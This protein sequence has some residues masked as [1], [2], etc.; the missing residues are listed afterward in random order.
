M[1]KL[2]RY[3]QRHGWLGFPIAVQK[4]FGEDKG[5]SLAGLIAYYGFFSLFPLL[6]LFTAVLGFV[7]EGNPSAQEKVVNTALKSFPG[8]GDQ[9]QARTLHGSG[10][11]LA[12][13][14][15]GTILS[16]LGVTLAVQ[17]AFNRVYAVPFRYRANFL[18]ARLRGLGTLAVLGVLQI[19]ATVAAALPAGG[20]GGAVTAIAG[21]TIGLA[22]NLLLFFVA[23]RLL[24]DS[25]VETRDLW[26]G[27]VC[28]AVAWVA[29]VAVGGIY[30]HHVVQGATSTYGTFA[31]V[32][33]LLTW[34][35]LG[36]RVVV[37]AA[38]INVVKTRRLWPRSLTDPPIDADRRALALMTRIEQ[39]DS[40]QEIE[41]IFRPPDDKSQPGEDWRH[42]REVY[43]SRG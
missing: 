16:G 12:V 39:R 30:V 36:A 28:A 27:I 15:A 31:L 24:T 14:A 5:G 41:V 3:Q 35:F 13:G 29:L 40:K 19:I 37:Y 38:E 20:L 4:K 8:I 9:L 26:T 42:G 43:R 33:G 1:K 22:L 34:L 21:I 7:L 25:S 32:I 18:K 6:L 11:A 17:D 10:V 23:F 2:D